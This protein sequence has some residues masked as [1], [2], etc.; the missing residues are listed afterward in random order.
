M[1]RRLIGIRHDC[2]CPGCLV[3]FIVPRE[4]IAT[5]EGAYVPLRYN[6]TEHMLELEQERIYK[7]ETK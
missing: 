6:C 4:D 2:P 3:A 7:E 1:N 5:R